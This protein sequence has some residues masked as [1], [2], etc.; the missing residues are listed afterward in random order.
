VHMDL[1]WTWEAELG[2]VGRVICCA[3]E[4]MFV[5]IF[6][7]D[8]CQACNVRSLDTYTIDTVHTIDSIS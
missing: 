1:V 3:P 6:F 5:C 4:P 8:G 7:A 2:A